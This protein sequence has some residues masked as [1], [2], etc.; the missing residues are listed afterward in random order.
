[1][2]DLFWVFLLNNQTGTLFC[3]VCSARRSFLKWHV[4]NVFWKAA[5][6]KEHSSSLIQTMLWWVV[7]CM[8]TYA[9]YW[10]DFP[11]RGRARWVKP[12]RASSVSTWSW[13]HL[14]KHM[15]L[16]NI[17]CNHVMTL[18]ELGKVIHGIVSYFQRCSTVKMWLSRLD[19]KILMRSL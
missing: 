16:L 19:Y 3:F 2:I 9:L 6:A 13:K 18:K 5:Q 7:R 12:G 14:G 15:R 4:K 8:C 17:L 10:Y 1:M 11:C